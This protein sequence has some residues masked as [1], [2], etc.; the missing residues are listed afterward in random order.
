MSDGPSHD[1]DLDGLSPAQLAQRCAAEQERYHQHLP[2]DDRYCLAL[3]HRA[4]YQRDEFAW[5]LIYQQFMPTLLAWL[6]QHHYA[7]LVLAQEKPD[8]IVNAAFSNFWRSTAASAAHTQQ[9]RTL[10]G[11]L[12]Y[13]KVCLNTAVVD[14]KRRIQAHQHEEAEALVPPP[15]VPPDRLS[16]QELW[17]LV[18]RALPDRR[19]LLLARLLFVY[20]YKPREVAQRFPRDFPTAQDV[21]RLTR[22]VLDR[23]RRNPAL[24]R[25]LEAQRGRFS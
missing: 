22:N 5:S 11:T 8:S 2:S 1:N 12:K 21:H 25:W 3:F 24:L 17:R 14:E 20:E 23:L 7:K 16:A 9:F 15:V 13:L 10:A 6:Y 4:I 18:E 19:E